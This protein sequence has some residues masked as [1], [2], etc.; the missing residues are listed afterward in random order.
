MILFKINTLSISICELKRQA[1]GAI[2]VDGITRRREALQCMKIEARHIHFRRKRTSI[3]PVKPQQ[4]AF[5]QALV[6]L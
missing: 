1:P 5:M 4:N 3:K 2:Y 6:N